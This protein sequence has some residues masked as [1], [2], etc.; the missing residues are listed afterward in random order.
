M[1]NVILV[2]N[3]NTGK[4]TL[5]NTLTKKNNRVGNWHGVTTDVSQT[6]I[7]KLQKLAIIYV[8]YRVFTHFL[9][10]LKKKKLL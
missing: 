8:I 10:I 9:R 1:R 7:K 3:P 4:T 5:F 2:G 6:K